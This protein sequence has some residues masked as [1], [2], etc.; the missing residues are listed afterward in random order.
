MFVD[1]YNLGPDLQTLPDITCGIA[2]KGYAAK[3]YDYPIDRHDFFHLIVAGLTNPDMF[4][5]YKKTAQ[6]KP[7]YQASYECEC[8]AVLYD[9]IVRNYGKT[10]KPE[11][12]DEQRL[13]TYI[14]DAIKYADKR[15][16]ELLDKSYTR[17]TEQLGRININKNHLRGNISYL[18]QPYKNLDDFLW[19]PPFEEMM[20]HAHKAVELCELV[21]DRCGKYPSEIG[22]KKIMELPLKLFSIDNVSPWDTKHQNE[23]QILHE[24]L[25]RNFD[26]EPQPHQPNH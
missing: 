4:M 7:L 17:T 3:F 24:R 10:I 23:R 22:T 2:T 16:K 14:D 21:K 15:I 9:D 1:D 8:F 11:E 19:R 20:W 18:K 12:V 25:Y 5:D 13:Y 26:T 6:I